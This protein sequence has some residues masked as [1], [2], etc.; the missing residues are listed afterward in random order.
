MSGSMRLTT[1]QRH[2]VVAALHRVGVDIRKRA[3]EFNNLSICH[4]LQE[5]M[6]DEAMKHD[7]LAHAFLIADVV[8]V[9]AEEGL[10]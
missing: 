7:G 6:E 4:E 10:S 5:A 9:E 3:Q 1:E 2:M 8:R